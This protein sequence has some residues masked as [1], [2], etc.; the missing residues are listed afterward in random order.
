MEN[1]QNI[2]RHTN[3]HANIHMCQ[4]VHASRKIAYQS[5][6]N[7]GVSGANMYTCKSFSVA[8]MYDCKLFCCLCSLALLACATLK[9]RSNEMPLAKAHGSIVYQQFHDI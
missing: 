4:Y 7:D 9:L 5:K 8:K 6:S 2:I 3:E 1:S